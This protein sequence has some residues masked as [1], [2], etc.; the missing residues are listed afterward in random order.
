[1]VWAVPISLATTFGI[2]V[3]FFSYLTKIF[4]FGSCPSHIAILCRGREGSPIRRSWAVTRRSSLP[5]L[6]AALYVLLRMYESRHPLCAVI[7]FIQKYCLYPKIKMKFLLIILTLYLYVVGMNGIL[8][9]F[10]WKQNLCLIKR[11]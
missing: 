4:Q 1:M 7:I 11:Q 9:T 6:I 3:D 10:W 8:N 2:S 5:R